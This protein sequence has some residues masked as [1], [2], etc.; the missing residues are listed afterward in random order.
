MNTFKITILNILSLLFCS[1]ETEFELD[2][3]QIEPTLI[4]EGWVYDND[5]PIRV[6]LSE[7]N[8]APHP[9]QEGGFVTGNLVYDALVT[10]RSN[11]QPID[12]LEVEF[13]QWDYPGS[14]PEK[15]GVI[16]SY[17]IHYTKLYD[18]IRPRPRPYLPGPITASPSL[19]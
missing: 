1:C 14:K 16:T 7:S 12:T 18:V 9:Q 17:S 11:K 6:K 13:I 15:T 4:V 8:V 10:V 5:I 2:Q 3:R 19:P